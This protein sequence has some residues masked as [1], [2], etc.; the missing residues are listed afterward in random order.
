MCINTK[1]PSKLMYSLKRKTIRIQALIRM[2]KKKKRKM[3]KRTWNFMNEILDLIVANF[4]VIH[5]QSTK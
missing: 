4:I 3:P 5:K 2:S 1:D